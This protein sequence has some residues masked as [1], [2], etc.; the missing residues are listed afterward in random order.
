MSQ[1][2]SNQVWRVARIP[3]KPPHSDG[4]RVSLAIPKKAYNGFYF[5]FPDDRDE[6][7]DNI[8]K[9]LMAVNRT[10]PGSSSSSTLLQQIDIREQLIK[11]IQI[12]EMQLRRFQELLHNHPNN[13]K[14]WK[15]IERLQSSIKKN[16]DYFKTYLKAPEQVVFSKD[17]TDVAIGHLLY[18]LGKKHRK[19][20]KNKKR[21]S[22]KHSS[23]K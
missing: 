16:K 12:Q 21:H 8:I 5:Q 2:A 10:N 3:Y 6:H 18:D 19:S 7:K 11:T 14:I 4:A 1:D 20:I 22:T 13:E 17:E 15:T 23:K 9:A